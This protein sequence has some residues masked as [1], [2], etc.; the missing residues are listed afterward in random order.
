MK[1]ETMKE[2]LFFKFQDVAETIVNVGGLIRANLGQAVHTSGSD[3]ALLIVSTVHKEDMN[4][5]YGT[6]ELAVMDHRHLYQ[7]LAKHAG[8]LNQE[9]LRPIEG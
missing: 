5:T 8:Q 7:F 9:S 6:V 1:G 3:D 4:L 2:N